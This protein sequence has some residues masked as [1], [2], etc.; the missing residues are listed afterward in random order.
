MRPPIRQSMAWLHAWIGAF[1]GWILYFV[2][3]TG[4]AT[5]FSVEIDRWMQPERP[6][7][8]PDVSQAQ[9]LEAGFRWIGERAPNARIW[10]ASVSSNRDPSR[11]QVLWQERED[12]KNSRGL[13]RTELLDADGNPIAYRKTYGGQL[14]YRMHYQLHYIPVMEARWIVGICTFLLL[15]GTITGVIIH[16]RIFRDLFTLRFGKGRRTWID[17]HNVLAV[18]T[19]PFQL[20]I[21]YSGLLFFAYIYLFPIVAISYG[22][23][24]LGA[25]QFLN[26]LS[27]RPVVDMPAIDATAGVLLPKIIAMTNALWGEGKIRYVEVVDPGRPHARTTVARQRD[28][29]LRTSDL[30]VFDAAGSVVGQYDGPSSMPRL[31]N[32]IVLGL[33][34][35]QFAS[36]PL[37]WMYFISGIAVAFSIAAGL[38]IFFGKRQRGGFCSYPI[39]QINVGIVA[40]LPISIAAYFWSN[41]LIP[42]DFDR[43]QVWEANSLF[44]TWML[45]LAFAVVCPAE[46]AMQR[47]L[48]TASAAF[49]LLPVI[50]ALTTHRHLGVTLRYPD[51]TLAGFDLTMLAIGAAFAFAAMV[52]ARER[53]AYRHGADS[54]AS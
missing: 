32:D 7:V 12:S 52:E 51:W 45:T 54:I 25:R 48:W 33:H 5:C 27:T 49:G 39:Q 28:G 20:M 50:N 24:E 15:I 21:A 42:A 19:L 44:V 18:F 43:R 9:L 6:L 4:A 29:P 14:L 17:V 34:E 26:D 41:R 8:S 47:L 38:F 11:L 37:R 31:I 10:V 13:T 22:S 3:I 2:F 16:R 30:L 23:G 1:A 53:G 40:G 46:K 35:A 36:P